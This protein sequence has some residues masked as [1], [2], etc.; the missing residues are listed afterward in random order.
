L[1][2][3][4]T[5]KRK[6]WIFIGMI[7]C[8]TYQ[9]GYGQNKLLQTEQFVYDDSLRTY[10]VYDSSSNQNQGDRPLVIGLHGTGSTGD[11]FMVNAGL[12]RKAPKENFIA[13]CP[14][15]LHYTTHT[16][17]NAGGGFEGLTN[18]ADDVGFIS[19]LIDTIIRNYWIDTTRIYVIGHSNG[20]ATAYRIAAVLS[21][22]IA[23]IGANSGQMVYEYCNPQFPVPIIHMHGLSDRLA[24]YGGR[25]DVPPVDSVM[26]IW[27]EKNGCDP[28]P[29]T[30]YNKRGIIGKKWTSLDGKGDI[31]L[32]TIPDGEHQW[33][34]INTLGISATNVFW[35]F[36]KSQSK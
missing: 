26:A 2:K 25:G 16:Y 23:G 35:D 7:I 21:H 33:P 3:N 29:D 8:L 34:K 6:M 24:P 28:V 13:V 10:F 1:Y 12:I 27:Q 14:N 4:Q 20:S 31:E 30:V 17:F 19:A 5:M 18:G 11:E 36:L 32:Y 22:R 9:I 15:A